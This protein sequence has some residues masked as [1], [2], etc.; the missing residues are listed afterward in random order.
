MKLFCS[1]DELVKH[2]VN[3]M[4]FSGAKQLAEQLEEL[5]IDFP[6]N[7]K[8]LNNFRENLKNFQKKRWH[9]S[10]KEAFFEPVFV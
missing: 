9:A 3:G 8:L 2:G 5:L 4:V 6:R 7:Q 1:L 10:W